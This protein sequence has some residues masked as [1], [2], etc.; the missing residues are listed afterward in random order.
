MAGLSS[1]VVVDDHNGLGWAEPGGVA[2]VSDS[3]GV[4]VPGSVSIPLCPVSSTVAPS[5]SFVE[6]VVCV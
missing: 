3:Q 2:V 5:T 6:G 4:V 1:S